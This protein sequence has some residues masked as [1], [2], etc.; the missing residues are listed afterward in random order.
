MVTLAALGLL[1]VGMGL[2]FLGHAVEVK[3]KGAPPSFGWCGG[4]WRWS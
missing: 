1:L 3:I 2:S 4:R